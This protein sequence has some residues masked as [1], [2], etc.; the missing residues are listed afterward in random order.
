MT[1]TIGA[2][3]VWLLLGSACAPTEVQRSTSPKDPSPTEPA[4]AV[5]PDGAPTTAEPA[6]RTE[7]ARGGCAEVVRFD[8]YLS[9]M[10]VP[11]KDVSTARHIL[12]TRTPDPS[13]SP[14]AQHL[15]MLRKQLSDPMPAL[16]SLLTDNDLGDS[17]AFTMFEL[18]PARAAPLVFA[19][20]PQS[21]RNVQGHS[22]KRFLR[23]AFEPDAPCWD[24]VVR[25]AAVRTLEAET[26]PDAAVVALAALGV[27]GTSA[28]IDLLRR[29]LAHPSSKTMPEFWQNLLREAAT[30]ALARRGDQPAIDSLRHALDVPAAAKLDREA[31]ERRVAA[32]D[33]AGFSR[34]RT[35]APLLCRHLDAP[36]VP[37]DGHM[38]APQPSSHAAMALAHMIDGSTP[39]GAADIDLWKKRCRDGLK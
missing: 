7:Q 10:N 22:F 29:Y 28:D 13:R 24:A 12:Q 21:D 37:P 20:M 1:R 11:P 32:I 18:D 30:A 3:I 26:N 25:D 38:L 9:A 2:S 36:G 14:E 39:D 31:A 17:A 4:D 35:L 34:Q 33:G 16:A 23:V 15:D 5:V 27:T 6:S 19:S 8:A